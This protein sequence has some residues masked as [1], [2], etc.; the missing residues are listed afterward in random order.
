L[1]LDSGFSIA[2][3]VENLDRT[4]SIQFEN[5]WLSRRPLPPNAATGL[6]IGSQL[7]TNQTPTNPIS[8]R[9]PPS[10]WLLEFLGFGI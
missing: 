6:P 4:S 10:V 7:K 1:I 9:R 5:F 8:C 3:A 2:P